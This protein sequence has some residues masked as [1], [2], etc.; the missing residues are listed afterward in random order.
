MKSNKTAIAFVLA[1]NTA[2]ASAAI[3]TPTTIG[4]DDL[5]A[6]NYVPSPYA[7]LTWEN[8]YVTAGSS[9]IFL[10]A[11]TSP[12]N[13][14]LNPSGWI[15]SFSSDQPFNF[16]SAN[17]AQQYDGI[18]L[19][20]T[21]FV[22]YKTDGTTLSMNVTSQGTAGV[23]IDFGWNSLYK[24]TMAAAGGASLTATAIDDVS[25]SPVPEP[26]TYA[27]LIAGLGLAGAM[28]RRRKKI[29]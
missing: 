5:T 10:N 15:A 19:F 7:G 13:V 17:I 21:E 29:A 23:L 3:T 6:G 8:F 25:V 1:L 27:M 22:G 18:S 20:A 4:F 11:L 24:V 12:P 2:V 28:A 26:E 14:G 9:G 16:L